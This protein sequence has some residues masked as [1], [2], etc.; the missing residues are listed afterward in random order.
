[1]SAYASLKV[2]TK[3]YFRGKKVWWKFRF[4]GYFSISKTEERNRKDF[5]FYDRFGIFMHGLDTSFL[6]VSAHVSMKVV[7]KGFIE[8]KVSKNFPF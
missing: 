1:M 3:G 6:E 8:V 7:T 5:R 4:L 2:A